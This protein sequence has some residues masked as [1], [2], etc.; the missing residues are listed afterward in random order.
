[1]TTWT[2][3][4]PQSTSYEFPASVPDGY[5]VVGY[6]EDGYIEP[7]GIWSNVSQASTTWTPS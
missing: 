3:A 5:V 4:S 6:V 7:Y 1:M 2:A